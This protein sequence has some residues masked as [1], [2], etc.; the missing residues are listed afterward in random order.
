M[1]YANGNTYKGEFENGKIH[2]H[3]TLT[4]TN[5]FEYDGNWVPGDPSG[6]GK[7]TL[8][9]SEEVFEGDFHKTK[10]NKEDKTYLLICTDKEGTQ[11]VFKREISHNF[12][13]V[14]PGD[15]KKMFEKN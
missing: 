13:I 9:D 8:L 6:H 14:N 12:T 4:C 10:T 2:G 1:T 7:L 5:D 3:G 11:H 15:H